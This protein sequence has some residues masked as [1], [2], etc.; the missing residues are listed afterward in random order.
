MKLYLAGPMHNVPEDNFPAF[1]ATAKRLRELGHTV[2]SPADLARKTWH[3]FGSRHIFESTY[4]TRESRTKIY[5]RD[6]LQ[7]LLNCDGLVTLIGWW[8]STGATFE[9][10]TA[11]TTGRALFAESHFNSNG[12]FQYT[13]I[14][15]QQLAARYAELRAAKDEKVLFT[16][17]STEKA[18][19]LGHQLFPK[20]VNS[21]LSEADALTSGARQRA[22]GHP[23]DNFTDIATLWTAYLRVQGCSFDTTDFEPND[24]VPN[25][26]PTSDNL[27]AEDVAMMMS[28]LKIAREMKNPNRDNR[29]DAPGYLG[30]LDII[31]TERER[32]KKESGK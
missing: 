27:D 20:A 30:C 13:E 4:F 16:A 7:A 26:E 31:R 24:S 14:T 32:R 12:L 15:R 5:M 23:L 22:Y 1:D 3:K 17:R 19:A 28:L 11:I 2:E 18:V 6:D 10:L 8:N 9:A 25:G 29:V 21:V